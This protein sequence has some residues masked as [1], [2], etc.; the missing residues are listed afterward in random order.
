MSWS[1]SASARYDE[2]EAAI[3]ALAVSPDSDAPE[4]VAQVDAAKA[5]AVEI[6]KSGVVVNDASQDVA[7]SISGHATPDSK[8]VQGSG[9]PIIAVS[10]Y[11][12]QRTAAD[13]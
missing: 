4:Q 7:I 6:V 12:V 5:A 1:G 8:P 10:V 13:A 2:A 3:G 11:Q 9:L